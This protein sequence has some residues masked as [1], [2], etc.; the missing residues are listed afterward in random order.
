MTAIE[1]AT[2]TE[3]VPAVRA[4]DSGDWFDRWFADSR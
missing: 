4:P 3:T 1:K 2:K